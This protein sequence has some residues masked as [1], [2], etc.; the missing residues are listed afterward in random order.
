MTV[1]IRKTGEIQTDNEF[2]RWL[3]TEGNTSIPDDRLTPDILDA[4]DAD[5]VFEG[6]QPTGEPWQQVVPDGVEEVKGQWRTK[7]RLVPTFDTPEEQDAYVATWE[8]AALKAQTPSEISYG[9]FFTALWKDNERITYEEALAAVSTR[10]IPAELD[11]FLLMLASFDEPGARDARLLLSRATVF[12]RDNY[13]VPVFGS[14]YG[15]TETDIDALWRLGA[16][17]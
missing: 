10:T 7:Y 17:L 9:Q 1:R 11:G 5:P 16:T 13:L 4:H 8:A 6:P 12:H 14:M 15:M 3:K 2:V